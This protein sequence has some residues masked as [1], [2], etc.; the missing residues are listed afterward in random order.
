MTWLLV[1]CLVCRAELILLP[2]SQAISTHIIPRGLLLAAFSRNSG[3]ATEGAQL[4]GTVLPTP[5]FRAAS[6]EN[7]WQC[8]FVVCYSGCV[9]LGQSLP[10]S[11]PLSA[12][13][14]R[15]RAGSDALKGLQLLKDQKCIPM[16]FFPLEA[17]LVPLLPPPPVLKQFVAFC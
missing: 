13:L 1:P 15:Q 12:H 8:L 6:A 11:G 5:F 14:C 10:L 17:S 2:L 7:P 16:W 9:T 3:R 4:L